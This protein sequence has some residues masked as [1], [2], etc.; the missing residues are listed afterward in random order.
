MPLARTI[1]YIPYDSIFGPLAY[2][3]SEANIDKLDPLARKRALARLSRYVVGASLSQRYQE[4]VHNK[5]RA[6]AKALADWIRSDAEDPQLPWL[7][8]VTIPSLKRLS[9][10]GA[11]GK[12]LLCLL[13]R[14]SFRDPITGDLVPLGAV[15][16]EDHHI[17]PTK[18]VPTMP[19][20]NA[21]T[22]TANVVLNI[23]RTTKATN[24]A[25]LN[26]N[27]RDQ[28]LQAQSVNGA[29]LESIL[30]DQGISKECVQVLLSPNKSAAEFAEFIR[31]RESEVQKMIN[32]E[33]LFP[34]GVIEPEEVDV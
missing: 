10:S 21:K 5:Q 1:S 17:F 4:G 8:E 3:W 12:M 34:I 6:D 25:Y 26:S 13:N 20:W 2:A 9:P 31:L 14:K 29:A 16:G 27:P 11:I 32:K 7:Q 19:G 15:D 24:A 28:I 23:M 30:S 22:M 33:V 18:F